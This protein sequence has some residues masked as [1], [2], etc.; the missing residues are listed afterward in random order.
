VA[1]EPDRRGPADRFR[2]ARWLA[3]VAAL[4]ASCTPR[5]SAVHVRTV[6]AG[7]PPPPAS[8]PAD[9][10]GA[11]EHVVLQANDAQLDDLIPAYRDLMRHLPWDV[12]VT[13][14]C[15]TDETVVRLRDRLASLEGFRNRPTSLVSV[16][17]EITV[18]ARDRMIAARSD[19]EVTILVPEVWAAG[20]TERQ[21]DVDTVPAAIH[22]A[23]IAPVVL[24]T[25]PLLIEGGNVL[26]SRTHVFVGRNAV[27]ENLRPPLETRTEVLEA[28]RQAF[29]KPVIVVGESFEPDMPSE[30]LDMYMTVVA[31]DTVIVGRRV[32]LG[33]GHRRRAAAGLLL[34]SDDGD[35]RDDDDDDPT[36]GE[37]HGKPAPDPCDLVAAEMAG[38]GFRVLRIPIHPDPGG[39]H[40]VTFNN[41]LLENRG[42][43]R[44]AYVPRYGMRRL[45]REARSVYAQ[46]GYEVRF[47]DVRRVY[48]LEGTI[49]CLANVLQRR[50]TP[51]VT[52]HRPSPRPDR[53][54]ADRVHGVRPSRRLSVPATL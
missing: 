20:E 40:Y 38:R 1:V 25:I 7:A 18:W 19:N 52:V 33:P 41:A 28:L 14:V 13:V 21:N 9:F 32:P 15:D 2:H 51:F 35:D 44:I 43:R 36:G 48:D 4:W 49:R 31:D 46:A 45:E 42:G 5:T 27:E 53:T 37:A 10:E 3:V 12:S 34:A 54:R 30:H 39:E 23:A 16:N 17:R 11:I 47:I 24:R 26:A 29:G 22:R 8:V 50:T 6:V